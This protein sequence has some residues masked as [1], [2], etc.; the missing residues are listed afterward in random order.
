MRGIGGQ[1]APVRRER[2]LLVTLADEKYVDQAKQLLSSAYWNAGWKGDY[3]LLSH[4]IPEI[5]LK[6][7]RERGI[8]IRKCAPICNERVGERKIIPIGLSKFY[9]FTPEFKKWKTVVYLDSDMIVRA[10]LDRMTEK[11]GFA[12]VIDT[13]S[14][15]RL[16][17]QFMEYSE[18]SD[19]K[20]KRL[21]R[22]IRDRFEMGADSF[23][24]GV[25]A[26]DTGMIGEGTFGELLRIFNRYKIILRF[27][28][29]AIFN[30]L[31]YK[32]W[33]RLPYAYNIFISH[34][35]KQWGIMRSDAEGIVLH[36][37]TPIKPWMASSSF[38]GEWKRNL[39]KADGMDLK[40]I[41]KGNRW[42][43]KRIEDYSKILRIRETLFKPV[44]IATLI[45]YNMLMLAKNNF[46]RR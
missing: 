38:Y 18:S 4:G 41:Q 40:K 3:M 32:K 13:A 29:Q 9:M 1:E 25:M 35:E 42:T 17:R 19:E 6:W 28:D 5:K 43:D 11:R 31:F 7:F 37:T 23:N 34:M 15:N 8:L 21:C 22:E 36:F 12:A 44:Y 26:F 39:D 24:S 2:N 30:I 46:P 33:E 27:T 16:G 14:F 10:S 20:S 45:G